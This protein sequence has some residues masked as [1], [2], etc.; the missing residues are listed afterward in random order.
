MNYWIFLIRAISSLI[1]ISIIAYVIYIL[2]TDITSKTLT[3]QEEIL[4]EISKCK[5]DYF[6]N[7][8]EN[9]NKP[10][11]L[12]NFC[13]DKEKCMNRDP[14]K[15]ASKTVQTIGLAAESISNFFD[16]MS[17]KAILC[18]FGFIFMPLCVGLCCFR[19]K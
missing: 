2:Y 8:C 11:E 18:L 12:L 9:P 7:K 10:R 4:F 16:S 17:L 6:I 3:K 5:S 14:F 19:Q 15:E 13:T 1:F